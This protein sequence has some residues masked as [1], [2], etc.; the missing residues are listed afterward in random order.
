MP[1]H[2]Q[3]LGC[4]VLLA[5]CPESFAQTI[6]H[7]P[8]NRGVICWQEGVKLRWK[9]FQAV[10]YPADG[11]DALDIRVGACC[12]SEVSVLPYK[13]D[14]GKLNFLVESV[15]IKNKSWVR[16]SSLLINKV[17]LAHEQLHF[18]INE[19]FAR[20]IRLR[21]MQYYQAGRQV[22]GTEL[23][24]EIRCLLEEQN[25]LNAWFDEEAHADP[26]VRR[27]QK[28]QAIVGRELRALKPFQ[29]TAATC[30]Q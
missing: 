17:Q 20:K 25:E 13:D 26:S 14:K 29:S 30:G 5:A 6:L 4:F 2:I 9:D 24:Q 8:A 16:D 18:D 21:I 1:K 12:A 10:N 23:G 27:L 19:L 11:R 22:Y 3:I 7:P 15:F 28:W